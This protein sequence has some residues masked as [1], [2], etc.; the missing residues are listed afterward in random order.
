MLKEHVEGWLTVGG[1]W[2]LAVGTGAQAWV[3]AADY[4]QVFT[5]LTDGTPRE[6]LAILKPVGQSL[7]FIGAGMKILPYV[8]AT[9]ITVVTAPRKMAEIRA[10]GSDEATQLAVLLR[11][12]VA[13]TVLMLG[14]ILVLAGAAI[15]LWF[16]YPS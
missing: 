14:S 1:L 3:A 13:W 10:A 8:V 11:T 12:T 4:R 9:G 6:V 16:T 2:L 5:R 7:S 15:Q